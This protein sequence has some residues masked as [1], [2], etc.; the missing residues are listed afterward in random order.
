M[1]GYC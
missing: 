1:V